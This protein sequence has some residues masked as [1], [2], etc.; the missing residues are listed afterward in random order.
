MVPQAGRFFGT[1]RTGC[2]R[3]LRAVTTQCP[4]LPLA[5]CFVSPFT[6]L[7]GT[8]SGDGTTRTTGELG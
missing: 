4:C 2:A 5:A 3:L 1:A 8:D 6:P 7:S